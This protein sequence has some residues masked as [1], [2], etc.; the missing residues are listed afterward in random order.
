MNNIFSMHWFQPD[1]SCVIRS[2]STNQWHISAFH[3]GPNTH[4]YTDQWV[5][6]GLTEVVDSVIILIIHLN[7]GS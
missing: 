2:R 4:S 3:V 6:E 5:P 1:K 7:G